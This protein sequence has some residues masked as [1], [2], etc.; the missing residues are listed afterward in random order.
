MQINL[1]ILEELENYVNQPIILSSNDLT[2]SG[3]LSAVKLG[4]KDYPF[5][6]AY[7]NAEVHISD[8]KTAVL[9]LRVHQDDLSSGQTTISVSKAPMPDMNKSL[10]YI[11]KART[12]LSETQLATPHTYSASSGYW[13][14]VTGTHST[15][16]KADD[17]IDFEVISIPEPKVFDANGAFRKAKQENAAK[18]KPKP[19][20]KK[21]PQ[22]LPMPEDHP[23]PHV[24]KYA[25][26]MGVQFLD[27]GTVTLFGK[28][29][30][31]E[32]IFSQSIT[33]GTRDKILAFG[34]A[35]EEKLK[36]SK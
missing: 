22:P 9:G 8:G 29:Y 17:I 2:V 16:V 3:I 10:I 34:T 23:F 30:S 12:D 33:G 36:D 27:D 5:P 14:P 7:L 20:P 21:G 32:Q 25:E 6:D 4:P 31:A 35:F 18:A 28:N 11:H 19:E 1:Y 15:P 26:K 24:W 13:I